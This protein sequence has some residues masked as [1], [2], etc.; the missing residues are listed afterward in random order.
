ML[1]SRDKG[2]RFKELKAN[3]NAR[4]EKT[5]KLLKVH[6]LCPRAGTEEGTFVSSEVKTNQK[7]NMS[8]LARQ[9]REKNLILSNQKHFVQPEHS[10]VS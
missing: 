6:L 4:G 9:G 5:R 7:E 1:E 2:F 3:E 8:G 10:C